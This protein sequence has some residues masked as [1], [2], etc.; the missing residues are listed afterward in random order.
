MTVTIIQQ[1]AMANQQAHDG[2][3]VIILDD[4]DDV[5]TGGIG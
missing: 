1:V 4:S 5:T 3:Y 2:M